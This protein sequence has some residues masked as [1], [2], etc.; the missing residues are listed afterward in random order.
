M[1]DVQCILY[2]CWCSRG[3][4]CVFFFYLFGSTLTAYGGSQARGSNSTVAARL[5]CSGSNTRSQTYLQPTHSSGQCWILNPLSKARDQPRNLM[6]P[7]WIPF[8]CATTGTPVF[9]S[10]FFF[11]ITITVAQGYANERLGSSSE[12]M[13]RKVC[14]LFL[15]LYFKYENKEFPLWYSRNEFV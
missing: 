10:S 2:K 6:V 5:H 4:F 8:R 13:R 14:I 3:F 9:F 15:S 12:I 11:T 1:H 7:S